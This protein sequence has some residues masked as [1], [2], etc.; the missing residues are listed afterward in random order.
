MADRV[1]SVASVANVLDALYAALTSA[2]DYRGTA[3]PAAYLW[4]TARFQ[5]TGVT[6]AVYSSPPSGSPI[7]GAFK[8]LWCGAAVAG[9]ATFYADTFL[10]N[11][12][13][14]GI[15]KGAGAFSAWNVAFPFGSAVG[16]YWSGF[17]R[18]APTTLN[19]LNAVVR[20]YVSTETIFV[21]FWNGNGLNHYPVFLGACVE[22]STDD[23]TSAEPDSRLYG[24]ISQGSSAPLASTWLSGTSGAWGD[25]DAN[26]GLPHAM[27]IQPGALTSYVMRRTALMAYAPVAGNEVDSSG[28][29][30]ALGIEMG[31]LSTGQARLGR[32]REV[33][34]L[35]AVQGGRTLRNGATDVFH[36]VAASNLTASQAMCLTAAP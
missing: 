10:S 14:V 7:T 1:V 20:V 17:D 3:L 9:S 12:L 5:N 11:G 8:A 24:R 33:Y 25:Q 23:L 29:F 36:V 30:I 32:L 21:D 15:A 2:T 26:N 22:P 16:S 4:T 34:H 28:N 31:R 19:V 6:E 27:I 35:G 13:M 18:V